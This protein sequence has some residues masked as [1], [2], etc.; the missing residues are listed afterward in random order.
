[1]YVRSAADNELARKILRRDP[2]RGRFLGGNSVHVN[3]RTMGAG[4][5]GNEASPTG[6]K[7]MQ[8]PQSRQ[9]G[10]TAAGKRLLQ[11][12]QGIAGLAKA[13]LVR[14]CTGGD[15]QESRR[16][17]FLRGLDR[18]STRL[19]SSHVAISYAVF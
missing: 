18:K 4:A 5:D 8:D 2:K 17:F 16:I 19:N 14:I 15:C 13:E 3:G 1:V 10:V 6:L 12:H 7:G 11:N 9:R